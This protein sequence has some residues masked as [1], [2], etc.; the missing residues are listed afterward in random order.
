MP[1][2]D[3]LPRAAANPLL[4]FSGLPRF[5]EIRPEHIGPAVELLVAQ[6][7]E[8]I[9]RVA[10]AQGA[11]AW[12]TLVQPLDDANERLARAWAQV[13]HLNAVVNPP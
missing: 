9:E 8:A 3:T 6:G 5:S 1:P 13:S 4:D 7:R 12:E 10:C 11:P 2:D